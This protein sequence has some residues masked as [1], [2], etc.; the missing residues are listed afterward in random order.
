[1]IG[2]CALWRRGAVVMASAWRSEDPGSN[3]A[4]VKGYLGIHSNAIV[5]ID[6]IRIVCVIYND[7]NRQRQVIYII[8]WLATAFPN[9]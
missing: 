6:L 4:R 5:K 7:N 9:N 3:P 1:M 8:K 2:Y